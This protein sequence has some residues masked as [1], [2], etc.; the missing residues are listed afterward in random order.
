MLRRQIFRVSAALPSGLVLNT[1]RRWTSVDNYTSRHIGPS[2]E[3]TEAMLKTLGISSVNDLMTSVL[4]KDI[5]RTPMPDTP[6]LSEKEALAYFRGM[7]S[8]NKNLKSL[9][10]HGYYE[11]ITPPAILRNVLENPAWYTPYTPYQA[12]VSQGRLESLLNYQTIITDLTK[13]DISNASLLD[14][15]TAAGE[16]MYMAVQ[17]HKHK[18]R[19]IFVSDTVFPSTIGMVKTRAEPLGIEVIVGPTSSAPLT[20]PQLAGIIVQTPDTQGFVHDYTELF[21][22]ARKTGVVTAVGTDLL[23]LTI[24]KPTG[25]MGADISYGSA[26]RFGIPLGYGGPHAAFFAVRDELKRTMP[27]RLI[28]VSKD[29]QGNKAIRMSLQTREQHIKRE[30]ATSNICTAQALLSNMNAF[31]AI[32][33]G[34][35]G[36]KEIAN[37]IHAKTKTL[38]VGLESI[39]HKVLN[40]TFFDTITVQLGNGLTAQ[41]YAARTVERGINI[42]TNVQTGTVSI[43]IDEA[44]TTQHITSLLE[45]AGLQHAEYES[46]AQFAAKREALPAHLLR[47]S[48]FLQSD[49]FSLNRCESSLMRYIWRLVRKD[50]G[51]THGM[52]PLGSCTMKLNSAATMIPMSWPEVNGLHPL[53]PADQ[54]KGYNSMVL[55][56]EQKLKEVTGLAAVSLQPNSGAQ[57]EYSGLRAIQAYH[58]SRGDKH[59]DICLIPQSAHGTNPASAVLA[60]LKIVTVKCEASGRIDFADLSK[61]CVANAANLSCIMVTYPST[62]G[63]FDSDIKKITGV[64]HEHGGQVYIDGANFN[65]MVGYTGPGFFGG[66][67]CHINLHKTFSIPH[68]GGGPGMGPI[69]V[70]EHLAPFL[71]N[72]VLGPKVGGSMSFGQVSQ[73]PYGSASILSISYMLMLMLGSSGMAKSTAFAVLNANYLRKRLEAHY[74]IL[75]VGDT[76]LCAHEFILDLRGLKKS[77]HIEAEDVAKRLMDYG[78]HAPTLAFPVPGTLMLEPTESEPKAELD[79]L[80]DALISIRAEIRDIEEGRQ[81]QE[82]NLLKN[83]PHTAAVVSAT[84]W[85][86]P[87]TRE[88]AAFPSPH[89]KLDKFWPTVSRI[90]G[91]YGDRHLM[92]STAFCDI[93]VSTM[94]E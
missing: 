55:D 80:A 85:N 3:E 56:L 38:A 51:L 30:K 1:Q 79:R 61:Q 39:G 84:N 21:A 37:E 33:H 90:D 88:Q 68:G 58:A 64:V 48:P 44:T 11:A 17:V 71:P 14:Q 59:R 20:D 94:K 87:Y 66:D 46:L 47:T 81:P 42:F 50:Y 70:R 28:G 89:T 34:P 63:V 12:E 23:A 18:R 15:A 65:A 93:D 35:D 67:V 5:V 86:R 74:P 91:A 41:Q 24:V 16:A 75:F 78:F 8:K 83:A 6:A 2:A 76:G 32:Y 45:A 73:A 54:A 82:N 49:V 69:A 9:I 10:G 29:A 52:I 77:A 26:Q 7:M 19:K 53:A 60:G 43:A 4:P 72:A 40:T 57:G 31:Y 25:E 13:M 36:L 27:G 62:Y 92:C 22:E